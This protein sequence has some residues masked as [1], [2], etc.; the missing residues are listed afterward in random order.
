MLQIRA[1]EERLNHHCL[2]H[3]APCQ[4]AEASS[5]LEDKQDYQS[6]QGM[7]RQAESAAI[8]HKTPSDGRDKYAEQLVDMVRQSNSHA[9]HLVSF[10]RGCCS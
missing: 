7:Y 10:E 9:V 8:A 1:G 3:E 6:N 5:E 4:M 2:R